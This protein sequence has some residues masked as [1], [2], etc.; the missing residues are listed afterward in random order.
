MAKSAKRS[1]Q[2][3]LMAALL[4][5]REKADEILINNKTRRAPKENPMVPNAICSPLKDNFLSTRLPSISISM[6]L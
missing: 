1:A 3:R 4:D 6:P 2:L 5:G